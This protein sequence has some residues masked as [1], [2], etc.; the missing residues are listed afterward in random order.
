MK[1]KTGQ[2]VASS[3]SLTRLSQEK[4]PGRLAFMLGRNIRI[5]DEI[6]KSY[7]EARRKM[8][9]EFGSLTPDGTQYIFNN[10]NAEKY[11][12][13]VNGILDVEQ[14]LNLYVL[15]EED[16][17]NFN[18]TPADLMTLEWMIDIPQVER[19]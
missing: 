7:D 15:T 18:C 6:L 12:K 2:L 16:I 17:A 9:I 5:I 14:D 8:L 13:E 11:N 10:G 1:I 19:K 3:E 4:L